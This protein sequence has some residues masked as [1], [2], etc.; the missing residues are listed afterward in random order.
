MSSEEK[1]RIQEIEFNEPQ[2]EIS[3]NFLKN[4]RNVQIIR[5]NKTERINH[6]NFIPHET[7]IEDIIKFDPNNKEYEYYIK[8]ILNDIKTGSLTNYSPNDTLG[9]ISQ[10]IS[11]ICLQIKLFSS[12][13][14][15]PHPVQ[16]LAILRLIFEALYNKELYNIKGVLGEIATGEGKSYIIAVVDII[17]TS[18]FGR[19]VDISLPI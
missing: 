6:L 3:Y 9:T 16:C 4:F 11:K 5:L 15:T 7:T 13:K 18:K 17:F 14:I 10:E 8:N 2:N 19:K 1:Y 12:R